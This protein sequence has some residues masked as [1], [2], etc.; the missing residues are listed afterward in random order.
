LAPG[1]SNASDRRR[2]LDHKDTAMLDLL[3]VVI[4]LG[5]FGAC[6]AYVVACERL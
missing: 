5:S 2:L 3:F 6:L 1:R 4:M